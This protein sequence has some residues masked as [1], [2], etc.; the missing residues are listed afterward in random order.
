[1]DLEDSLPP[2]TGSGVA[3]TL[4]SSAAPSASGST[5]PVP[6]QVRDFADENNLDDEDP[7]V[8]SGEGSFLPTVPLVSQPSSAPDPP[9]T[10]EARAQ[11]RDFAD[12]NNL[13]DEDP[14]TPSRGTITPQTLPVLPVVPPASLLTVPNPTRLS[15][16]DENNFDASTP[17]GEGSATPTLPLVP[18]PTSVLHNLGRGRVLSETDE[19]NLDDED[20]LSPLLQSTY[21]I[22]T[23]SASLVSSQPSFKGPRPLSTTSLPPKIEENNLDEEHPC[24]PSALAA[25]TSATASLPPTFP[26]TGNSLTSPLEFTVT[27]SKSSLPTN[28]L[29]ADLNAGD[30]STE[31]QV[32]GARGGASSVVAGNHL[33]KPTAP[34][35]VAETAGDPF[36]ALNN[37]D[38]YSQN[39]ENNLNEV[40]DTSAT[41]LG[42]VGVQQNPDNS[43]T[44][45]TNSLNPEFSSVGISRVASGTVAAQDVVEENNL[46]EEDMLARARVAGVEPSVPV[47]RIKVDGENDLNEDSLTSCTVSRAQESGISH[48]NS[49]SGQAARSLTTS[50]NLEFSGEQTAIGVAAAAAES[51][52]PSIARQP[53]ASDATAMNNLGV[54]Q[55][56]SSPA[57]NDLSVEGPSQGVRTLQMQSPFEAGSHT[58]SNMS[59]NL[60]SEDFDQEGGLHN[61][62]PVLHG[63]AADNFGN[64]V[65]QRHGRAGD[66]V[67]TQVEQQNNL[68][69]QN[70]LDADED[71]TPARSSGRSVG[72][73][74]LTLNDL[75]EPEISQSSQPV[76]TL[77]LPSRPT[78]S[79]HQ[80]PVAGTTSLPA[81][82]AV[83]T[84]P[85]VNS[86]SIPSDLSASALSSVPPLRAGVTPGTASQSPETGQ[87]LLTE[88]NQFDEDKENDFSR[89]DANQDG[90]WQVPPLPTSA[91]MQQRHVRWA[92]SLEEDDREG[93]EKG[94]P[95]PT[96]AP[97]GHSSGVPLRASVDSSS[98]TTTHPVSVAGG[99]VSG[100]FITGQCIRTTCTKPNG[101]GIYSLSTQF[102][103]AHYGYRTLSQFMHDLSYYDVCSILSC[104][105][106][107][108]RIC[109]L[110]AQSPLP[111]VPPLLPVPLLT[112]C[113]IWSVL[114]YNLLLFIHHHFLVST[115]PH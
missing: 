103:I 113:S 15:A 18:S 4:V 82:N 79:V 63:S 3:L 111:P 91:P 45:V 53:L 57:A 81:S 109:L 89:D 105:W 16:A 54:D 70:D 68:S 93:S 76:R 83:Y 75:D 10:F 92:P 55:P 52:N 13:N 26:P 85:A 51:N 90:K 64:V 104:A 80:P 100:S 72:R 84:P 59:N 29:D 2:S 73:D 67:G 37:L 49:G 30:E 61:Q 96:S 34:P 12:E 114:L 110:L 23:A 7:L 9:H 8:T 101:G 40:D 33:N 74:E 38:T 43:G 11:V 102:Y 27:P 21:A 60:D 65:S 56:S 97:V 78:A 42:A 99:E 6:S 1:M 22:P 107:H 32:G 31:G 24:S 5:P 58:A 19:N 98:F 39:D 41:G 47:E 25:S 36:A 69:V 94:H 87:H 35:V 112:T 14:V 46:D 86:S 115:A 50:S 62:L 48:S 88:E 17:P 66:V 77:S 28:S 44:V 106:L 71:S 95:L 20:P 108:Y